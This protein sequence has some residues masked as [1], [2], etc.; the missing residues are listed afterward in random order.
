MINLPE[1]TPTIV[2]FVKNNY[3][4]ADTPGEWTDG[5]CPE[6]DGPTDDKELIARM[7]ASKSAAGILGYKATFKQLWEA[8][9]EALGRAFPDMTGDRAFDN[10]A[11]DAALCSHLA[12]WTGKDCERIDRLF[13]QSALF[14]DKWDDRDGY[15]SNRTITRAVSQC[16]NVYSGQQRPAAA[17]PDGNTPVIEE[18]NKPH[19]VMMVG[20][21]VRILTEFP[22]PKTGWKD[23]T[24]STL[25]DFETLYCNQTI[26]DPEKPTKKI[27]IAKF[28]ISHPDR[29]QFKGIGFYPGI[30]TP[31]G[32]YN[33]YSGHAVDPIQGDW[34]LYWE[35]I[36]N[37][38]A[39]GK[40]TIAVW[41]LAWIARIIQDPGGER[42]GTAIVLRGGQGTGKGTFVNILGRLFGKHYIQL[43]DIA[44]VTGRFN[45]HF[46]SILLAFFDEAIWAGNKQAEGTIKRLITEPSIVVEKKGID[47]ISIDNYLN[48]II[49]SNNDWVVP[50]GMEERR[51]FVLDISNT[52]QQDHNY[53]KAI[54][55]QM[56]NGGIEAL[57]YYLVNMDIS[58]INLR[59]FE[60]T[61]ALFQQKYLS[62]STVQQFWFDRLE[63]GALVP[64]NPRYPEDWPAIIYNDDLFNAYLLSTDSRR[65]LNAKHFGRAFSKL[66][67]NSG[68]TRPID[69]GVRRYARTIPALEECR[70]EFEKLIGAKISWEENPC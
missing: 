40:Q 36:L 5:P 60:K 25:A 48:L 62:M 51:F 12:F 46:S 14:R 3:E 57:L 19:A 1:M 29:R 41:I 53:F 70:T 31:P 13:R 4:A 30:K 9:P 43:S 64:G 16:Q 61:E 17:E 20:G 63:E 11:A 37:V 7:L 22:D 52:R 44:Q 18:M 58:T 23:F 42:P 68:R 65:A 45:F 10:S 28:W 39:D 33:L 55:N 50:A 49:A 34:G 69:G 27:S 2:E 15:Y 8:D 56:N 38:I 21:K 59:V 35:F 26:L 32:W 24:L 6:Y 67:K 66:C 54:H 47:S